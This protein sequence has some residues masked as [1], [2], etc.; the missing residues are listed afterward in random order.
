ME[1]LPGLPKFWPVRKLSSSD[2]FLPEIQYL[3]W[4]CNPPL[5]V[6]FGAKLKFWAL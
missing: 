1:K 5:I 6:E 4:A 2:S 3:V